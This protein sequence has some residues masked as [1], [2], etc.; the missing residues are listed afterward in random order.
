[1]RQNNE[2]KRTTKKERTDGFSEVVGGTGWGSGCVWVGRSQIIRNPII[3]LEIKQAA[4]DLW[5]RVKRKFEKWFPS[6]HLARLSSAGFAFNVWLLFIQKIYNQ[7]KNSCRLL[8]SS[9]DC[10]GIASCKGWKT[11]LSLLVQ[12]KCA[13]QFEPKLIWSYRTSKSTELYPKLQ[14]FRYETLSLCYYPS[15]AA[16]KPCSGKHKEWIHLGL[17]MLFNQKRSQP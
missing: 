3:A 12:C 5:Q 1:M 9:T 13:F 11:Q 8:L 4:A 14:L 2:S 6:G 10:E 16:K 15:T 17:N 7:N